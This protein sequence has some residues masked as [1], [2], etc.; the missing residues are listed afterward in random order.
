M[1]TTRKALLSIAFAATVAGA[2]TGASL[3]G[4]TREFDPSAACATAVWPNIP[5][6]CID[7]AVD[8]DIRHVSGNGFDHNMA[9]RFELAFR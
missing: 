4:E 6:A 5:A 2:L 3:R 1:N 8:R 9:E 7:G